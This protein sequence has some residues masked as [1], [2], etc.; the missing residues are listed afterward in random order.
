MPKSIAQAKKK[1]LRFAK[2]RHIETKE[3]FG[4]ERVANVAAL[5]ALTA[6]R[7][8]LANPAF[9]SRHPIQG[10][11]CCQIPLKVDIVWTNCGEVDMVKKDRRR[12][13]GLKV[14]ENLPQTNKRVILS[15]LKAYKEFPRVP[16]GITAEGWRIYL[17]HPDDD[18]RSAAR[19]HPYSGQP[20]QKHIGMAVERL[21][22][23]PQ[24]E[25]ACA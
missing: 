16:W 14:K 9:G 12:E 4:R 21:D 11:A 19:A 7:S 8:L 24:K 6:P 23:A 22:S 17:T 1:G 20:V 25:K 18:I 10:A 3:L 5:M 13:A 15:I 2:A